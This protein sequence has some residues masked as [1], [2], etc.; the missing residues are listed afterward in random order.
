[1]S[2]VI[3]DVCRWTMKFFFNKIIYRLYPTWFFG[4]FDEKKL[5]SW[6]NQNANS[7]QNVLLMDWLVLCEPSNFFLMKQLVFSIHSIKVRH[8]FFSMKWDN[9]DQFSRTG[10]RFHDEEESSWQHSLPNSGSYHIWLNVS[11]INIKDSRIYT[12]IQTTWHNNIGTS[13]LLFCF[14]RARERERQQSQ[15]MLWSWYVKRDEV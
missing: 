11:L 10:E 14:V 4:E 7:V 15:K 5:Y 1:M 6:W 9:Q 3:I 2:F 12:H 13:F 8:I